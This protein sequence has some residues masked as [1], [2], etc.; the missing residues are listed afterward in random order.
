MFKNNKVFKIDKNGN[1]KR[2]LG[3]IPGFNIR[4]KGKNSSVILYEPVPK[5]S[6]CKIKMDDNSEVIIKSS[7]ERIKKLN[8]QM[9]SNQKCEIGK[10]F[11]TFGCEIVFASEK[12]L[13]VKIGD[14]CLFARNILIRPSDGHSIYSIDSGK[15]LNFGKNIEIGN[16]VWVAGD[17]SILKG[18]YVHDNCVI[19][20]GAIM[21]KS[22]TESYSIYAGNPARLVKSHINWDYCAPDA[23]VKNNGL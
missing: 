23:F 1:K 4:F 13:S 7:H 3:I 11:F 22:T 19:G 5:F 21:T 18:V 14:N 17:V 10:E 6:R 15:A 2:I 9:D 20:H 8:I 16:H 12:N